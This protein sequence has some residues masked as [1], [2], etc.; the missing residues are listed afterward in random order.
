MQI[1]S[2]SPDTLVMVDE[3]QLATEQPAG[4]VAVWALLTTAE[5]A[6]A[7][8]AADQLPG[9]DMTELPADSGEEKAAAADRYAGAEITNHPDLE[10]G[11]RRRIAELAMLM[12][13]AVVVFSVPRY[14]DR[15]CGTVALG[16]MFNRLLVEPEPDPRVTLVD[17]DH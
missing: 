5:V 1:M 4:M 10:P 6:A 14:V 8:H 17:D 11:N 15:V 2:A 7:Y 3:A 12:D 16:R 9:V 13:G